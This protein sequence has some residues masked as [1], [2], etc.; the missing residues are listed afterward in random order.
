[1]LAG[2][3]GAKDQDLVAGN[4]EEASLQA[5]KHFSRKIFTTRCNEAVRARTT[6]IRPSEGKNKDANQISDAGIDRRAN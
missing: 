4:V 3:Q 6:C 2:Q 1:V 5:T